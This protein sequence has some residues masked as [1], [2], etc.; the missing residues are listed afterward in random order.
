MEAGR[1]SE[2]AQ[3]LQR[4]ADKHELQRE[5]DKLLA[6]RVRRGAVFLIGLASCISTAVVVVQTPEDAGSQYVPY[7]YVGAPLIAV[8]TMA[9]VAPYGIPADMTSHVVGSMLPVAFTQVRTALILFGESVGASSAERALRLF[10]SI[11][12]LAVVAWVAAFCWRTRCSDVWWACMHAIR[13]CAAIRLAGTLMLYR[14]FPRLPTTM[15]P[16]GVAF[17]MSVAI[18]VFTIS[19]CTLFCA[20]DVRLRMARL[21]ASMVGSSASVR[22]SDL[23]LGGDSGSRGGDRATA[24]S[25]LVERDRPPSG[26]RQRRAHH[27]RDSGAEVASRAGSE[28]RRERC[29]E[30]DVAELC[31]MDDVASM[32]RCS[33]MSFVERSPGDTDMHRQERAQRIANGVKWET[34]F[35]SMSGKPFRPN[36][37]LTCHEVAFKVNGVYYRLA[38]DGPFPSA[39]RTDV[40]TFAPGAEIAVDGCLVA[41]THM[42]LAS[43]GRLVK[44]CLHVRHA[45][46]GRGEQVR[47]HASMTSFAP[48]S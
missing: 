24:A 19:S 29:S 15:Y 38:V 30:S 32:S 28:E 3:E 36:S 26:L 23:A 35:P 7:I 27:E 40:Y 47:I 31:S 2:P 33:E 13:S 45:A 34:S 43:D 42:E 21:C 10:I 1:A 44:T 46:D 12:S 48:P 18:N 17:E 14:C 16:P 39:F 4:E 22:L 20:L 8:F 25:R 11:A 41:P 6:A 37:L 5:A 9:A